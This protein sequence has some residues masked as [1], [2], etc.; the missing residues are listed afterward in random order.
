MK[1]KEFFQEIQRLLKS[2]LVIFPLMGDK[3]KRLFRFSLSFKISMAYG[4]M[5]IL[6]FAIF[7]LLASG[8]AGAF[9][10]KDAYTESSQALEAFSSLAAGDEIILF[11]NENL[12]LYSFDPS[13]KLLYKS[14]PQA[15]DIAFKNPNNKY[16]SSFLWERGSLYLLTAQRQESFGLSLEDA[17][18]YLALFQL[19]TLIKNSLLFAGILLLISLAFFLILQL[20]GFRMSNKIL[21]PIKKMT[22]DAK[23]ISLLNMDKRLDVS[24]SH[25]ELKDLSETFNEMLDRLQASYE[26]QYLFISDVS[27]ELRTPISVI[28]GYANLLIRWGK[29]DPKVLNESL[30]A[31][32][33]EAENMKDLI[34]KLLFIA[35][36]E[37]KDQKLDKEIFNLQDLLKEIVKDYQIL[38]TGHQF[39]LEAPENLSLYAD[40]K[41]IK[42]ALR[43][44]TDNA[45]KFT[46]PP[47]L[48]AL[49]ARKSNNKLILSIKDNGLGIDEKDLPKIFDRFFMSDSSREKKSGGYGLGLS[50]AKI[51]LDLHQAKIKVFSKAGQG[52]EIEL[53]FDIKEVISRPLS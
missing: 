15:P 18:N 29:D 34:E 33:N 1:I 7:S 44:F 41:L 21:R 43:I 27:H 30:E 26:K 20:S 40:R 32:K 24:K 48:I 12:Y 47:G 22:H 5:L 10:L 36:S 23:D 49:S 2:F 38:E 3:I 14:N 4:F 9:F 31:I 51:I 50:I 28:Q 16:Q 6:S 8:L 53:L 35:R 13:Q 17:T 52:T 37:N 42:Q 39:E 46:P 45:V 25:D 19:N 11:S